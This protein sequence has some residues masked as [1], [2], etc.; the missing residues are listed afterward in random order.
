MAERDSALLRSAGLERVEFAGGGALAPKE[1][2]QGD[3][4]GPSRPAPTLPL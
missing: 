2:A 3:L 1:C 4:Q